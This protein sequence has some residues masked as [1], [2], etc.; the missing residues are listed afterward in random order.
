MIFST[1]HRCKGME[2]DEVELVNDFIS[3]QRLEKLRRAYPG[4]FQ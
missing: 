1:V 4:K 3:E 2:Y